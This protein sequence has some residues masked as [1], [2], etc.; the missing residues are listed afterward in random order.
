MCNT[1]LQRGAN[2]PSSNWASWRL[3]NSIGENRMRCSS[4][5]EKPMKAVRSLNRLEHSK[6]LEMG[7][8]ILYGK[9]TEWF[10]QGG[11][12]PASTAPRQVIGLEKTRGYAVPRY[13]I[14][15]MRFQSCD[16]LPVPKKFLPFLRPERTHELWKELH[17]FTILRV[18]KA[19]HQFS[20][21][22]DT[23]FFISLQYL[24]TMRRIMVIP[25]HSRFFSVGKKNRR[26]VFRDWLQ[27]AFIESFPWQSLSHINPYN[28]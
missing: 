23:Q 8:F 5:S 26:G 22:S 25:N 11:T 2:S 16:C 27:Q 9:I 4:R 20:S 28:T 10:N 3:P 21:I 1:L 6:C 7:S 15:I 19:V 17:D 13:C 14:V 18:F 12:T 24:L